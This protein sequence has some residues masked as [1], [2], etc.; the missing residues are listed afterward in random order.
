M[1]WDIFLKRMRNLIMNIINHFSNMAYKGKIYSKEINISNAAFYSLKI[2]I[3]SYFNTYHSMMNI[4]ENIDNRNSLENIELSNNYIEDYIETIIHFQHF[5]ELLIKSELEVKHPLLI[6]K[7]IDKP[8]LLYKLIQKE[9]ISDDDYVKIYSIE[10]TEALKTFCDL[11]KAGIL[12]E[13][14]SEII[15]DSR[16]I[17][18][19]LNTFRNRALH[20]GVFILKYYALDEF[21]CKYVLPIVKKIVILQDYLCYLNEWMFEKNDLGVDI[22]SEMVKE[23]EKDEIDYTKIAFFKEIGRASYGVNVHKRF[24]PSEIEKIKANKAIEEKYNMVSGNQCC[25]VCGNDS[26]LN[27]YEVDV[28]YDELGDE[29]D[30]SGGFQIIQVPYTCEKY[31]KCVHC[32]FEVNRFIQDPAT[33]GY[34]DYYFWNE[35]V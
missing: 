3:K 29:L 9:Q 10:F 18:T 8:L 4:L 35:E 14:I 21:V 31:I 6:L 15:Y 19:A 30:T 32:N 20:R 2:A 24:L 22:I 1:Q 28:T 27:Y 34:D 26:L 17:L 33:Y 23:F 13:E 25:P 5:F 11:Y 16:E 7:I 12:T